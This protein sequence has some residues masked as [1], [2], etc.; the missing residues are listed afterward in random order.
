VLRLDG[1]CEDIEQSDIEIT[2]Q[3]GLTLIGQDIKQHT[4]L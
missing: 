2:G 1:A 4:H 3:P